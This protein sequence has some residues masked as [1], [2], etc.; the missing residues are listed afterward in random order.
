MCS[1]PAEAAALASLS[2]R[3]SPAGSAFAASLL[4]AWQYMAFTPVGREGHQICWN[5]E[6]RFHKL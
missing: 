1:T 3:A 5:F 6:K 4:V 2:A